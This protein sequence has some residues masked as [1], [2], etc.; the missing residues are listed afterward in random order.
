M[1]QLADLHYVCQQAAVPH[2][3][4]HLKLASAFSL[5]QQVDGIHLLLVIQ[6]LYQLMQQ[7]LLARH[8]ELTWIQE[9]A[10]KR[11]L[12]MLQYQIIAQKYVTKFNNMKML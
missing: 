1:K 3:E 8:T 2:W 4:T 11:P 9:C 10:E 6:K 7:K 12:F 5:I